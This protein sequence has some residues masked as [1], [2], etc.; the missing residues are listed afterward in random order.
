MPSWTNWTTTASVRS[1]RAPRVA[2]A[3]G[4]VVYIG[5][6]YFFPTAFPA[7]LTGIERNPAAAQAHVA[8]TLKTPVKLLERRSSMD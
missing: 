2:V 7:R 1:S 6:Y 5:D 3:A 8:A 4:E